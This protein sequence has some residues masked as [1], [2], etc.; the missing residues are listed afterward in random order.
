MDG[1]CTTYGKYK[2]YIQ[3]FSRKTTAKKQILWDVAV[4]LMLIWKVHMMDVSC[5][6]HGLVAIYLYPM[7]RALIRAQSG[8]GRFLGKKLC[9]LYWE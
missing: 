8:S 4:G 1:T 9:F 2:K 7:S 3:N 6:F 5:Q